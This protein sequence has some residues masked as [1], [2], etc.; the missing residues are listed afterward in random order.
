MHFVS[1][2]EKM[3]FFENFIF[4]K[5]CAALQRKHWNGWRDNNI[6]W[7]WSNFLLVVGFD[8]VNTY[9]AIVQPIL[10]SSN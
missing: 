1:L 7:D 4:S 3:K 10:E 6:N 8:P 9:V 2:S 5:L